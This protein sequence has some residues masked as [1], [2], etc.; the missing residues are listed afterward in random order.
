MAIPA[1]MRSNGRGA[2]LAAT[3]MPTLAWIPVLADAIVQAMP[4]SWL[5]DPDTLV[6]TYYTLE[7]GALNLACSCSQ[8]RLERVVISLGPNEIRTL[9]AEHGDIDITCEFCR[10][11]YHFEKKDLQT[12]LAGLT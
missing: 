8:K 10:T 7:K 9:I 1:I 11:T 6:D 3:G 5:R 12:I 2:P 4:S